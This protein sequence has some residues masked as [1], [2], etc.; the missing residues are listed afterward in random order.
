MNANGEPL[1]FAIN[2]SNRITLL[3][4][5]IQ[6]ADARAPP[7]G[8]PRSS[9]PHLHVQLQKLRIDVSTPQP[10]CPICR[11][12]KTPRDCTPHAFATK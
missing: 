1:D 4:R 8:T 9:A 5:V 12:R 6:V 2:L 7:V 3:R 10:T 11:P